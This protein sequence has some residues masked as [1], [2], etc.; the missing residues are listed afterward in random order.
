MYV[1]IYISI[2]FNVEMIHNSENATIHDI[3]NVMDVNMFLDICDVRAG[4]ELPPGKERKREREERKD[5][6]R[7]SGENEREHKQVS[8]LAL[9]LSPPSISSINVTLPLAVPKPHRQF[10]ESRPK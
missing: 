10:K 4:G 6:G 5:S 3:C 1:C 2:F 7:G 8:R 9:F